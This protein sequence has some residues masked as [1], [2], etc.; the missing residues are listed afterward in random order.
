M[1]EKKILEFNRPAD[2]YFRTAQKMTETSNYLGALSMMRKALEKDEGNSEYVM[3]MAE[4]LTELGKYEESNSL[5]FD[6]LLRSEERKNE[7]FFG[8]GCNFIGLND[9]EKAQESFEKY[10]MEEPEGEFSEDVEEFL[11]FFDDAMEF[12]EMVLEDVKSRTN[13]ELAQEGKRYLDNGEYAKAAEVLEKINPYDYDLFFAKNNL[14][15]SYYCMGKLDQAV[16]VTTEVLEQE[17]DNIH[18]VCNMALFLSERGDKEEAVRLLERVMKLQMLEQDDIF[19]IAITLCE[20]K[21]H[22]EALRFLSRFLSENPYDEK[23]LYFAAVASFN[24]HKYKDALQFLS[25][26]VKLEPQDSIA[27]YY[28]GYVK[29]TMGG[30]RTHADM[31]YIYQVP[32]AEARKRMKYL[33]DCIKF[34][35]AVFQ[36]LWRTEKRLTSIMLWGLEYGDLF[37]KRAV[38]EIIGNL[39]DEKAERVLRRY[40]LRRGQPDEVKN[41]IFIILK[42]IGAKEPYVA[43]FN[44]AI[45][46]VKVGMVDPEME[47]APKEYT[48]VFDLILSTSSEH[49]SEQLAGDAASL[50]QKLDQWGVPAEYYTQ[51]KEYAA[52]V[53]FVALYLNKMTMEPRKIAE[54]YHADIEKMSEM[55]LKVMELMKK[56]K[57]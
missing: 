32:S 26:I 53:T 50:L 20:L 15:L 13:Q 8:M 44:G 40:L 33:N 45:V 34:P 37:I 38:A 9:F 14:A 4:I 10:V 16:K 6:M 25:D 24:L 43:Y 17:P 56:E 5:L 7:C 48:A 46:E 18:A 22:E 49:F 54:L 3:Q 2:F 12:D 42:R 55:I 57:E 1:E 41:D 31:N 52:T 28:I 19:K 27:S 36:E 35:E 47:N 21:Q 29:E 11:D 51:T 23:A 30:K 39:G